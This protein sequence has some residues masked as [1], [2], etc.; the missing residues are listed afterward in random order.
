MSRFIAASGLLAVIMGWTLW[1][2]VGWGISVALVTLLVAALV[3]L[4]IRREKL[5]VAWLG[6]RSRPKDVLSLDWHGGRIAR[7]ASLLEDVSR[8]AGI[9]TPK[10]SIV[11]AEQINAF[12]L[13]GDG[14]ATICVTNGFLDSL[15]DEQAGALLALQVARVKS[16]AAESASVGAL[17]A[18]WI[19]HLAS[20]RMAGRTDVDVN[21]LAV[22]TAT[23]AAPFAGFVRRTFMSE[24]QERLAEV[25]AVEL[26]QRPMALVRALQ[27]AEF[28]AH[29][30]PMAI[31]AALAATA[32][33][34]PHLGAPGTAL[35]RVY[36][37]GRPVSERFPEFMWDDAV[38]TPAGAELQ[39]AA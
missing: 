35:T 18:G 7:V 10:L 24:R 25:M 17:I 16:G 32:V 31:P 38:A 19:A 2:A 33:V 21:P 39:R 23:L 9:T 27:R 12:A 15:D 30:K 5:A 37:M 11:D 4:G 13:H 28:T 29:V 22:P 8:K 36:G 3:Y 34:N 26:I 1:T 20:F 14:E 6:A